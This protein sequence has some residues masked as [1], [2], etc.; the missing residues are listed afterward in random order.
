MERDG[1]ALRCGRLLCLTAATVIILSGCARSWSLADGADARFRRDAIACER[2]AAMQSPVPR[3]QPV[4]PLGFVH[5]RA[6][7]TM[8]PGGLQNQFGTD[9]GSWSERARLVDSCMEA[10]GYVARSRHVEH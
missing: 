6:D 8:A 3:T 10:K 2:A 1:R 9:S 4:A 5:P 7:Y